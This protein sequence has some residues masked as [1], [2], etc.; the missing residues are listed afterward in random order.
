MA[1][2]NGSTSIDKACD[3][4]RDH[5]CGPCAARRRM[6][7]GKHYCIDCPDYLCDDCEDYHGSLAGT[8][9]HTIV[10][11]SR[12]PASVNV[13][14]S[15]GITCGCN[16]GQPVAFYCNDHQDIICGACKTFNHH[17]CKTSSI[18][19][20][21]ASYKSSKL[22]SILA[23]IKSL[24]VKYERLNQESAG[25]KK[26]VYQLNEACKKDIK[27]FRK[28]LHTIFDE[29]E[30]NIL[31]DV[32]KCKQDKDR[33]VD[34]DMSTIASALNVLQVDCKR[35]EDA[36][37]DGKKEAMFIADVQV[38]KSIQ[39]YTRKLAE[40]EKGNKR[41]TLTFERNELLADLVAGIDSLG[42]L[43][44]QCKNDGQINKLP[45]KPYGTDSTKML[46]DR[47]IKSRSEVNV[48]TDGDKEETWITGSTV[49]P[50]GH[51]VL[52]DR[53]NKLIK[54]L[55]DSW[56]VTGRLKIRDPWD[57]SVIDSNNAIVSSPGTEQLQK[58]QVLP[59]MKAGSII[60]LDRECWGVA[61]THDVVYTTCNDGQGHGEVRV[62]DLQGNIKRRLGINQDGPYLF[63]DPCHITVSNAGEKI[64]VSDRELN[65]DPCHITVSNA[66]EKIFVSD[67]ELNTVTCLT[68]SGRV[69]YTYKDD[70][71]RLPIGLI[72]DSG[73]NVLVCG[74]DSH[75]VQ[76]ISPDG[77][78]HYTLLSL[79]DGL[80]FPRSIAYKESEDTLIIGCWNSKELLLFK[81]AKV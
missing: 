59:K 49:M 68:S 23:E 26:E 33:H 17:K 57:V 73:D 31:T 76:T 15:L 29:L 4:F 9:H 6:K 22:I 67:R 7:E 25:R 34:Q 14:R 3:E 20:K 81:L 61:M 44:S 65:T 74:W 60:K 16:K 75:N 64:F 78:K 69:I 32:D 36:K 10:P 41:P 40:L 8:R 1:T 54:L 56:T 71:L 55:D 5:E 13:A 27:R 58:V 62:L 50:N 12:I 39:G 46:R 48:R 45:G 43:T 18:R 70:D 53:R 72:C 47:T 79:E 28:E 19:E 52:C 30:R 38:S 2:L 11:S 80:S 42:S 77:N 21:S 24:N 51:V 63:T 66:G 35:L 37:R